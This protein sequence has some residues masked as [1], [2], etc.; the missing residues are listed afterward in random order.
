MAEHRNIAVIGMTSELMDLEDPP[1][2]LRCGRLSEPSLACIDATLASV[3]R[4]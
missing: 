4:T 3:S 2:V 1:V